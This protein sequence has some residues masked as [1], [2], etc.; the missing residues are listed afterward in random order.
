MSLSGINMAAF[1][2]SS[3]LCHVFHVLFVSTRKQMF[4]SHTAWIVAGMTDRKTFWNLSL[5]SVKRGS[6]SPAQ[7]SFVGIPTVT[8]SI[9]LQLPDPAFTNFLDIGSDKVSFLF[10]C[11]TIIHSEA[12]TGFEPVTSDF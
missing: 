8:I 12:E 7:F 10:S 5:E 4:W 6:M 9:R 2:R 1:I 3:L 11:H